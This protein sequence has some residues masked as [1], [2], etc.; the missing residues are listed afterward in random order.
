MQ[1]PLEL[2]AYQPKET[3]QSWLVYFHNERE[4]FVNL[5]KGKW[6]HVGCIPSLPGLSSYWQD[7]WIEHHLVSPINNFIYYPRDE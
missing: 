2:F 5:R 7:K 6:H 4:N 1:S 3:L